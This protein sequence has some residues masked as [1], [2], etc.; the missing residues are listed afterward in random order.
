M[1][2]IIID[3]NTTEKLI[4]IGAVHLFERFDWVNDNWVEILNILFSIV[5]W[6][7]SKLS[8]IT[9]FSHV[10]IRKEN[11]FVWLRFKLNHRYLFIDGQ[12]FDCV[13]IINVGVRNIAA[14]VFILNGSSIWKNWHVILRK[15]NCVSSGIK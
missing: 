9:R 10:N 3:T 11:N 1:N 7:I 5:V 14:R 15:I 2:N 13:L 6:L 12:R 8:W 4:I